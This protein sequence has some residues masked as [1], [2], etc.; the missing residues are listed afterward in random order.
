MIR[1]SRDPHVGA[2]TP[3]SSSSGP[4]SKIPA[5][6]PG[7]RRSCSAAPAPSRTPRAADR[8]GRGTGH[9]RYPQLENPSEVVAYSFC[10]SGATQPT[11]TSRRRASSR[12]T[13]T[14]RARHP[15]SGRLDRPETSGR[16][17]RISHLPDTGNTVPPSHALPLRPTDAT[18]RP[19]GLSP[20]RLNARAISRW[21]H[22]PEE[23]AARDRRRP[24][25]LSSARLPA[26]T[27]PVD[28][29]PRPAAL[30]PTRACISES[31]LPALV[32][33][34]KEAL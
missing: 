25:R 11:R 16:T 26:P 21:Q 31:A 24:W 2:R 22:Y 19:S 4:T 9:R 13:A 7:E 33:A 8:A 30:L 14:S 28:A 5:G 1:R 3:R 34:G 17:G 23:M 15:G 27:S 12:A 29:T 32:C 6:G 10:S 18:R 20:V